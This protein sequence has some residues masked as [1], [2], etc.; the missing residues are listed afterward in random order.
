M[1]I[2]QSKYKKWGCVGPVVLFVIV[3]KSADIKKG[4]RMK[5]CAV[6]VIAACDLNSSSVVY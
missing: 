2:K 4:T 5:Y 3:F 6:E 1:I